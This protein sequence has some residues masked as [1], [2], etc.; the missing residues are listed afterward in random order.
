MNWRWLRT[1]LIGTAAALTADAVR[2]Q[3]PGPPV[4]TRTAQNPPPGSPLPTDGLMAPAPPVPP[5]SA[6][7]IPGR[8]PAGPPGAPEPPD[9]N[10]PDGAP[11]PVPDGRLQ[12]FRLTP[13]YGRSF[14][15][16]SELLADG[17]RR[18]I[19][20][21]G[22]ILN[23]ELGIRGS[24]EL[25]A[26]D[27][28]IWTRNTPD[29]VTAGFDVPADQ[30]TEVEVYLAGN[31]IV[32]T[33]S[34]GRGSGVTA[35][36]TQILRAAQVYYDIDR[37]RAVAMAADLELGSPALPDAVHLRAREIQRLGRE[38]WDLLR[39]DVSASK[40]PSD[41]GLK[42]KS[43]RA[44]FTERTGPVRNVFGIPYRDLSTGEVVQG[45]ERQL[46]LRNATTWLEGVPVFYFPW[47]R[48]DP[49]EPLGPL[50]G[51]GF[52]Q[53]R[54]FG[55]QVY[56][57]WDVY[58]LL[59]LK[60]PEGHS[61]GLNL[62]YLGDRGP[63][64][65][66]DYSYALARDKNVGYTTRGLIRGYGI[67]DRADADILGGDRNP[68]QDPFPPGFRG[69]AFWRHQQEF[70]D[71]L[72]FQ[73]QL[74]YVSDQNF[75]EQYYKQE[76]DLGP[77]QETFAHLAY[78][79]GN[80]WL[81]GLVNPKLARP[82]LSQ[83]EYLPDVRGALVGQSFFDLF[84]YNVRGGAT[85]AQT[86]PALIYP[87]PVLPT[88][89]RTNTA[90]FD[91]FQELSLPFDLGPAKLAP[92]GVL[93]L[94]HYT[95]DL[96]GEDRGRA[97]GGG[98]VRGT[99]PFSRLYP[100]VSSELFNVRGLY[101]KMTLGANWYAARS[102][103][104]YTQLPLID[105]LN[106]DSVE[107]AY[108]YMR[109]KQTIYV[110]GPGGQALA[111]APFY[112]PQ[113]YAIRR[114][115]D[116]RVDTLDSINVVQLNLLQRLQTKRG[117]PGFE[118]TVDVV[119]LDLSAS[120]FPNPER[121]NYGKPWAFMEYNFLWNI[122]DRVG[123]HSGGWFDPFDEGA[124]YYNVGVFLDRP[125]R[126]SYYLGYRQ[127]DPVNSKQVTGSFGYQL[128]R[129]YYVNAGASYDFGTQL[130]LSNTLTLTRTGSDLTFTIGV[131]YNALVNNFGVQFLVV[132]NLLA[133]ALPGRFQ[134]TA[135][136]RTQ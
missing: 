93:D 135:L 9:A 83:T 89:Q 102:D 36:T 67:D 64:F 74:A 69:R 21:G 35:N 108:R 130:S 118:H 34:A 75:L 24:I 52:G 82:W 87:P 125:D 10:I 80:G 112:D 44:T 2:A 79:Q 15:S 37:S 14:N 81:G 133:S 96:T 88:D 84:V 7:Q 121:D 12:S 101:H 38:E 18:T 128:S 50:R 53:D 107:Q 46:T 29:N 66:T 40:L 98:G 100:D 123:V 85:Y 57:T 94:T 55:T 71:G 77:N 134:P 17:S 31:V 124:R 131:T 61:W 132:P 1:C 90:R 136:G 6:Y 119:N 16:S 20:S 114:L 115:V 63:G 47:L 8:P 97:Y 32:R 70:Y 27:A 43:S 41:P 49:A 106:D 30:K 72:Y 60:P 25:A 86:R 23:A 68:V 99:V 110:P 65:G 91:L 56:S 48:V 62:D 104:P 103:T 126:T 4:F 73:G 78:Q 54:I 113:Q 58:R 116:N 127:T 92:Y 13:R 117:Y 5:R 26:D 19:I 42:I 109:L 129:R 11:I 95:Q 33:D 3:S 120:Y 59:A 45:T 111:N 76:W 39:M 51:I 22:I 28:V 122:G 105:R